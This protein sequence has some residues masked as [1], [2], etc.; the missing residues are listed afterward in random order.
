MYNFHNNFIKTNF[1]AELVF[2]NT[3]SLTHEIKW[4]DVYEEFFK[5]KSLFDFSEYQ[6]NFFNLTNETVIGKMTDEYKGI[7]INKF[8]GL[9][10][11]MYFIVSKNSK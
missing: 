11:K 2:S 3:D 9:K 7:L 10:S 1:D 8:V 4:D 5:H 6:P